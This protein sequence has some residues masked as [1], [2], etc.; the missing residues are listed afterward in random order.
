MDF[1]SNVNLRDFNSFA[2]AA[3]AHQLFKLVSPD[4]LIELIPALVNH[5]NYVILGGGSNILLRGD[6]PGL[7]VV[8]E[9]KGITLIEE[10]SETVVVNVAAGEN[11]HDFVRWSLLNGYYGLENLSLIPGTVGA[12][13]IQNIG[14]YGVEFE[15]LF[16]SLTL[17]DLLNASELKFDR[18]QCEFSYRN[19]IF[20]Q[21][22]DRYLIRSVNLRL[23]KVLSPR[24]D[25]AGIKDKLAQIGADIHKPAA[26]QISDAIC[27]LRLSKLPS[28]QDLGNAGSFFKN[29]S[30]S[31]ETFSR[32]QAQH[33]SMPSYHSNDGRIK[34]PAA[35]LIEQ[36]GFKGFRQGDAGVYKNHALVIVNYGDASGEQIWQ[37]AC[38]IQKSVIEKF[39]IKLEP[40]PRIL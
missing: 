24:L 23:N 39:A 32:L 8:N 2:V 28:P 26:L 31:L 11:W 3:S 13:P 22:L 15:Q 7:V 33:D 27:D 20:K 16:E 36:C 35:W 4:Q 10:N 14:A 1:K 40:E 18:K 25:Y 29:P 6:F 38:R 17:I 9:L 37:L 30:L 5:P 12:A 34:I 21:H 19:S